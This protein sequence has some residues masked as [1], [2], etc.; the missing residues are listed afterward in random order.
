M[1]VRVYQSYGLTQT[2][3][4]STQ[5]RNPFGGFFTSIDTVRVC[6]LVR[7]TSHI[8]FLWG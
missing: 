3:N 2:T 6:A 7:I 1:P 8:A 5:G 4:R